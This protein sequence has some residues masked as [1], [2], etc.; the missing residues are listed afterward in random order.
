M[1][2]LEREEYNRDLPVYVSLREGEAG[3]NQAVSVSEQKPNGLFVKGK[4]S[5]YIQDNRWNEEGMYQETVR[6]D[7]G[8]ERFYVEEGTGLLLEDKARKGQV[9]V[10]VKIHNGYPVLTNLKGVQAINLN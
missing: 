10:S 5:P 4:M 8:I 6:V 9:M 2:K 3:I 7:Y 1:E